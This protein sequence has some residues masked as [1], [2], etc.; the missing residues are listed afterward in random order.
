MTCPEVQG[1]LS[2]YLYGELEFAEEERLEQH[3]AECAACH[4]ALTREKAWHTALNA[5]R[6]D[7][8]LDLLEQCRHELKAAVGSAPKHAKPAR[9]LNWWD[10]LFAPRWS[11]RL[12]VGSFLLFLGFSA[13]R[14]ID[15]NGLPGASGLAVN[16]MGMI[17][18]SSA[19][20]REIEP[21]ANNRVRIVFDEER[22]VI[23]PVDSAEMRA[24]LLAAAKDEQDPGVRVDSVEMLNEQAS[25]EVRDALLEAARTDPNAAVR[26]KAVEGLERYRDDSATRE[27]LVLVLQ[28][29]ENA[30]VRSKAIDV[31]APLS[32]HVK[33]TPD[34]AGALVEV[35]RTS[36]PDDYVRIRC[37]E[38]LREMRAPLDMY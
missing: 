35:M 23:G 2:L 6:A 8:P 15:R 10:S 34:L 27:G 20:I 22:S 18:P 32:E 26:L 19:R 29:D 11:A 9:W 33:I 37:A 5:E 7:V 14:L 1:N 21:A 13:A 17:N 24:W 16:S 4:R 38:A 30:G 31:L 28:H 36:L 25:R 12:A 3:V